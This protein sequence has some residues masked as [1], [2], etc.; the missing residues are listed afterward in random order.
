MVKYYAHYARYALSM[1]T[2]VGFG[3]RFV[4]C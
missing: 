2:T 4:Y 3:T 1:L